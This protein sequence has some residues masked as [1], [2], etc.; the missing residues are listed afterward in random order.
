MKQAFRNKKP[1]TTTRQAANL[2]RLLVKARFE[3]SPGNRNFMDFTHVETVLSAI[4][5]MCNTQ[6]KNVAPWQ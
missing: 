4:R 2:R 3:L 1:L 5:D 6:Q